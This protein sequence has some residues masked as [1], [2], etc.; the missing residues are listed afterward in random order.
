[1]MIDSILQSKLLLSLAL[2]LG[3]SA[4]CGFRV[5]V[6]LLVASI[7]TKLNIISIDEDFIWLS[8]TSTIIAF[9]TATLFEIG[10]Y[11]LPFVDNILDSITTPA[12]V[13][14]GTLLTT[15][16]LT[17]EIDPLLQWSLGIIVGGGSAGIVQAGTALARASS[18]TATA[19]IANPIL[20]TTEHVFAILGSVLS[21]FIPLIIA[22]AICITVFILLFFII[23]Y[24]KKHKHK[25]AIYSN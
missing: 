8:N 25:K 3:L 11:Y 2:G 7:A 14:A 17:P 1:M 4:C 9:A 21:I 15:S 24:L 19:G 18:S 23:R 5:F 10:G 16:L 13:V 6:P 22:G 12:S 20:A